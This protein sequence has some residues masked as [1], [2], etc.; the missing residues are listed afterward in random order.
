MNEAALAGTGIPHIAESP[1]APRPLPVP[2]G[3]NVVAFATTTQNT[4]TAFSRIP[5]VPNRR[6]DY[7]L[8]PWRHDACAGRTEPLP[9]CLTV[10]GFDD[11]RPNAA[12]GRLAPLLRAG[13]RPQQTSPSALLICLMSA[14][15]LPS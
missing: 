4:I 6:A 3:G 2:I 1:R 15:S 9:G 12:P 8:R 13:A 14:R 5:A 10:E 7:R 11:I